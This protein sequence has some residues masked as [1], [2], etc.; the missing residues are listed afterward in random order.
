MLD[1]K[2]FLILKDGHVIYEGNNET[3]RNEI[4][5][6]FVSSGEQGLEKSDKKVFME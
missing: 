2:K 5:E 6:S 3:K 1:E 4:Y